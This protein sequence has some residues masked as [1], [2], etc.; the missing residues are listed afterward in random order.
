MSRRVSA[1][2]FAASCVVAFVSQASQ[3][4]PKVAPAR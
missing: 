3:S 1:A 4:S 2:V